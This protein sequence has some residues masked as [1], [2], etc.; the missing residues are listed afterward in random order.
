[1]KV[2][3]RMA[4]LSLVGAGIAALAVGCGNDGN[5]TI[6]SSG[7]DGNGGPCGGHGQPACPD[8]LEKTFLD[9]EGGEIRFEWR[10]LP[11]GTMQ[12]MVGQAW[13][14]SDQ[15][16]DKIPGLTFGMC[17]D[18]YSY[19][20]T[21]NPT[22]ATVESR[23]A[24]DV[25]DKVTLT[26]PDHTVELLREMNKGDF[27]GLNHE[28]IY[29]ANA[30]AS[31][32]VDPALITFGVDY[33]I[34]FAD[35]AVPDVE[36]PL[37]MPALWD[38]TGGNIS[39]GMATPLVLNRGEDVIMQYNLTEEPTSTAGF[40]LWA[41]P[42]QAW[43]CPQLND[44]QLEMDKSFLDL[45]PPAGNLLAAT[46]SHQKVDMNGRNLDL[47]GYTCKIRPYTVQ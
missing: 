34:D 45:I 33:A 23:V 31:G 42:G 15:S 5:V 32:G 38:T 11:D 4:R 16:P 24:L 30:R 29:L 40:F 17:T 46:V 6:D 44:G 19:E 2:Y 47:I 25:G 3:E 22:I 1:M 12:V 26:S 37:H 14:L 28:I 18:A 35:P 20:N 41:A 13:F 7:I 43:I 27:R 8:S 21:A 10:L 36:E 9:F 39:F